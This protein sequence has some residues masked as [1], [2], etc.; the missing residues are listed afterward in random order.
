M[1]RT[2]GCH[3][4]IADDSLPRAVGVGDAATARDAAVD[5]LNAHTAAGEAPIRRRVRVREVP[6]SQFPGRHDG[7]RLVER[8]RQMASRACGPLGRRSR[9]PQG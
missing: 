1:H 9:S 5:V 2:S 6:S 7:R 3:D 4:T 8:E